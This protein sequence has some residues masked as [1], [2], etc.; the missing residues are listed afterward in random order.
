MTRLEDFL[1]QS[2]P[3]DIWNKPF[4]MIQAHFFQYRIYML[5][6]YIPT[7]KIQA[8]EYFEKNSQNMRSLR[9]MLKK[10]FTLPCLQGE[11]QALFLQKGYDVSYAV[12]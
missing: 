8:C 3:K 6:K 5:L 12:L 10:S 4:L 11:K 7:H 1:T 2:T 9:Y